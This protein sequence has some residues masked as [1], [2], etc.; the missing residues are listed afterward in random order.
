MTKELPSHSFTLKGHF[1]WDSD[2]THW[3]ALQCVH[4]SLGQEPPALGSLL[5]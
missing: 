1:F 2:S 5:Q 3:W 4:T